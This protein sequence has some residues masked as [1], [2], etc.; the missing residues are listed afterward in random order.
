MNRNHKICQEGGFEPEGFS[1]YVSGIFPV[2]VFQY[3]FLLEI[4]RREGGVEPKG[5]FRV[6]FKFVSSFALDFF[7]Y[8]VEAKTSTGQIPEN[9]PENIWKTV[10]AR[11]HLPGKICGCYSWFVIIA[12]FKPKTKY[13]KIQKIPEPSWTNTRNK[14]PQ[15]RHHPSGSDLLFC[16]SSIPKGTFLYQNRAYS[17][18]M[19]CK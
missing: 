7:M 10:Q 9:I 8:C 18:T 13:W 3:L 1:G 4:K 15:A 16:L 19:G 14:N 6:F 12:F 11:N 2:F 5:F 17:P